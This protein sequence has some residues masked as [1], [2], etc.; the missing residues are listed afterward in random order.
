VELIELDLHINDPAFAAK[1]AATLLN[2]LP[3][4]VEPRASD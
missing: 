2:W 1:A 4:S 3:R